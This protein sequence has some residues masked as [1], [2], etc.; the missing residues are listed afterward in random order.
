MSREPYPQMAHI[1]YGYFT[2]LLRDCAS[3]KH[4]EPVA[5]DAQAATLATSKP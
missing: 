5:A 1:T 2:G 4:D 3:T